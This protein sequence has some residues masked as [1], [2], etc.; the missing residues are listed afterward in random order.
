MLCLEKN[1]AVLAATNSLLTAEVVVAKLQRVLH[2]RPHD[3]ELVLELSARLLELGLS[4]S[5]ALGR[6]RLPSNSVFRLV[7]RKLHRTRD[8]IFWKDVH[9]RRDGQSVLEYS[10]NLNRY[11]SKNGEAKIILSN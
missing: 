9:A 5:A 6:H 3:P 10:Q 8:A 1:T 4:H 7:F 11:F 2:A